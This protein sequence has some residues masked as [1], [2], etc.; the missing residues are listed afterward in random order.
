[1]RDLPG[2]APR[3]DAFHPGIAFAQQGIVAFVPVQ[4]VHGLHPPDNDVLHGMITESPAIDG[5]DGGILPLLGNDT[6]YND[7]GYKLHIIYNAL[8]APSEKA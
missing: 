8:A 7:Y 1:M 4:L 3:D 5:F 6:E 2:R